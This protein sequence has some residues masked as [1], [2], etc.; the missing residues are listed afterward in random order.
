MNVNRV[1]CQDS[2]ARLVDDMVGF[3]W[4]IEY[5]LHASDDGIQ[6]RLNFNRAS[7]AL[8]DVGDATGW[9]D[10]HGQTARLRLNRHV[11]IAI[12]AGWQAKNITRLIGTHQ[13]G[14]IIWHA[15]QVMNSRVIGR[16]AAGDAMQFA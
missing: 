5:P 16:V 13:L 2:L 11:R 9:V 1:F 14:R 10:E 6:R 8:S 4:M 3:L 7:T 15:P 12:R